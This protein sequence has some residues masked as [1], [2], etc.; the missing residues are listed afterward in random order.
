MIYDV[1]YCDLGEGIAQFIH[2]GTSNS[3]YN[4][5]QDASKRLCNYLRHWSYGRIKPFNRGGWVKRRDI[6]ALQTQHD[7]RPLQRNM[8]FLFTATLEN[9]KQRFQLAVLSIPGGSTLDRE[10]VAVEA[11]RATSGHS[12]EVDPK[13]LSTPLLASMLGSISIISH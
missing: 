9:D 8:Y 10:V 13:L 4:A 12:L 6:F 3:A 2:R 1:D 11:M 5:R 7:V